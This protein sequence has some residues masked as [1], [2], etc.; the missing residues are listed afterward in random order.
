MWVPRGSTSSIS[1]N[2]GSARRRRR[3]VRVLF[4]ALAMAVPSLAFVSPAAA[5]ADF[6]MTI[7]PQSQ[8]LVPGEST[9]FLIRIGSLEEF[10]DPV[11]LT[12]VGTVPDKVTVEFSANPVAPPGQSILT[13]AV[14]AG[15]TVRGRFDLAIRGTSG[16]L[17][18]DLTRQA[19]VLDFGLVPQCTGTI[20]GT[21]TEAP[22]GPLNGGALSGV[23]VA[24]SSGTTTTDAAGDYRLDQVPLGHNNSPSEGGLTSPRTRTTGSSPRPRR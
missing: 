19:T 17:Q 8:Q 7:D 20:V 21:V 14:A 22:G 6:T 12:V 2:S 13:V 11:T 9:G 15:A 10:A 23:T 16:A 18:H 4:L 24:G 3:I 5:A 1:V